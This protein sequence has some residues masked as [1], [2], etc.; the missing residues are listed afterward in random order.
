[1]WVIWH[2]FWQF[3]TDWMTVY[4]D[5]HVNGSRG[6]RLIT[7][8]FAKWWIFMYHYLDKCYACLFFLIIFGHRWFRFTFVGYSTSFKMADVIS[9]NV[10]TL[11]VL[12][13]FILETVTN[14][15]CC[16]I[17]KALHSL[18]CYEVIKKPNYTLLKI[19]KVILSGGNRSVKSLHIAFD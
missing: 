2:W 9:R 19:M 3:G 7:P 4:I 14:C 8:A 18:C 5:F 10:P 12:T 16:L 15:N 17:N 11:W 6:S 1:M 13:Y